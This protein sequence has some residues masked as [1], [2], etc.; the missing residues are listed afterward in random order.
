M[1]VG[2]SYADLGRSHTTYISFQVQSYFIGFLAPCASI[3]DNML[4]HR[5]PREKSKEICTNFWY[6]HKLKNTIH[7]YVFA[8]FGHQSMHGVWNSTLKVSRYI[9]FMT[10]HLKF[11]VFITLIITVCQT[12]LSLKV[13]NVMFI[14]SKIRIYTKYSTKIKITCTCIIMWYTRFPHN[15]LNISYLHI[16][17]IAVWHH[18]KYYMFIYTKIRICTKYSTKI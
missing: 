13:C 3:R 18:I 9:Y 17:M 1:R 5:P 7:L 10:A 6:P 2:Q 12:K 16:V 4:Y 15:S 11:W 14:Y 8:Y